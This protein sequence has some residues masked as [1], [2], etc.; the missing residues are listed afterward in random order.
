MN[1]PYRAKFHYILVTEV[2]HFVVPTSYRRLPVL[3]VVYFNSIRLPASGN[4]QV[5]P[6]PVVASCKTVLKN[7]GA[8]ES[9][10]LETW[11]PKVTAIFIPLLLLPPFQN[12]TF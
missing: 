1:L 3:I 12:K 7:V 11:N 6:N 4:V 8:N 10:R 2:S 5:L 9:N